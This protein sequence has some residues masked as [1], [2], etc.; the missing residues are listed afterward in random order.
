VIKEE[1]SNEGE[2]LHNCE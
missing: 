2:S 1:N